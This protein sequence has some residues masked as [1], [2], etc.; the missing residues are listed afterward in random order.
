[1]SHANSSVA[2]KFEVPIKRRLSSV[3]GLRVNK[4]Y[5]H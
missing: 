3:K 5:E 1:M 2:M 4:H